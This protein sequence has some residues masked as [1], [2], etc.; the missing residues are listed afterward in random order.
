MGAVAK[1]KAGAEK[2]DNHTVAMESCWTRCLPESVNRQLLPLKAHFFLYLAG[3]ACV[4]PYLA[5][6]GRQIGIN[7]AMIAVIF[8]LT[9]LAAVIIK[10]LCGFVID[11]TQNAT[12]VIVFLQ[13]ILVMSHGVVFFSPSIKAHTDSSF[14]GYLNCNSSQLM[15]SNASSASCVVS[16]A[17]E[18][19]PIS[20][21]LTVIED[22]YSINVTSASDTLVNLSDVSKI[23]VNLS[24]NVSDTYAALRCPC[25]ATPYEGKF[26]IYT[27][28][29]VVAW[30]TSATLYTVT[31]A[32]VCELLGDNVN[33]FGRQRLWGTVSWGVVSPLI[34]FMI[35]EASDS[36]YTDYKPGFYLFAAVMAL[37]IILIC[38][39][40]RLRTADLSVNFL[41]D[42]AILFCDV[43]IVLFTAW[44]FIVGALMGVVWSFST[45]YLEDL[46]A[47]KLMIGL[48]NTVMSLCVEVPLFFISKTILERVGYFFSYSAALLAFS[49]KFIGYS[50]LVNPWYGLIVDIAGGAIFPLAYSAMTVFAK[51]ASTP[52]TA[53][54]MMCILGSAFEGLGIAAGN[55]LG[56]MS[57]DKIGARLTFRYLGYSSAGCAIFCTLTYLCL[58]HLGS[59][60]LGATPRSEKLGL[61]ATKDQD[62]MKNGS[63]RLCAS[64]ANNECAEHTYF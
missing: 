10:P 62:A 18:S 19:A 49:I 39:M 38:C 54:S 57:I 40:P 55:L 24:V 2:R 25:D 12:A 50:Y 53:A 60:R 47:S 16:G 58:R 46:H 15:V 14:T 4:Y 33:A 44:T 31:D 48:T 63:A 37:D 59:G 3:Q 51:R 8:S 30:A 34:G 36:S 56:G 26:W 35:D 42:I 22:D 21:N 5:V 11:R 27:I 52:G 13:T 29:V 32:A 61:T 6:I 45:W 1:Q 41:R 64:A 7:A 20:C 9:P 17:R 43:E 28:S 23:C